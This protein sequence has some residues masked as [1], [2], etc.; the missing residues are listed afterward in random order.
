MEGLLPITDQFLTTY[1]ALVELADDDA[2]R[3]I[4]RAD[5]AH[6]EALAAF[7]RRSLGREQGEPLAPILALPHVATASR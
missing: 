4:A 6:E 3:E 7:A 1:R 2:E 5:V